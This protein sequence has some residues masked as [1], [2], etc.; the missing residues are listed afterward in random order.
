MPQKFGSSALRAPQSQWSRGQA[1]H[2]SQGSG[3]GTEVQVPTRVGHGV[4]SG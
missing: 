3:R 2:L 1:G 4:M